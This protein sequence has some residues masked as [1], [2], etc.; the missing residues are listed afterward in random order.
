MQ[1]CI[2]FS[3]YVIFKDIVHHG[4]INPE[5]LYIDGGQGNEH[6]KTLNNMCCFIRESTYI[7][8]LY[9]FTGL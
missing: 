1:K 4:Y 8:S 3:K 6:N 5:P 2:L 9:I 7:W